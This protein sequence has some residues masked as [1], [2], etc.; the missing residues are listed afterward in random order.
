M[1]KLILLA[2]TLLLI[3]GISA[4]FIYSGLIEKVD[5]KTYRKAFRESYK[6]FT[7]EIPT[8]ASFADEKAPLDHLLVREKLDRE[9]L[10][11]T[12]WHTSTILLIKRANRW[13]PVIEPILK[14]NNIPDDFKYLA[15]IESGLTNVV[16]PKGA[17]GFW[18]FMEDTA[19]EY[20]LEVNDNVDERYNVEKSTEA[21]CRYLQDVFEEYKS[22]T[23]VAAAYNA[24]NRRIAES[25][26]KQKTNNYYDLHLNEETARYVFRILS[27]KTI[28]E[29]PTR[30]GFYLRES[31]LY[32]V[33]PSEIIEV[34]YSL[35]D[36]GSFASEH[37]INYQILKEFNPWL[38]SGQLPAK[39]GKTYRIK[40]PEKEYLFVDRHQKDIDNPGRIFNDTIDQ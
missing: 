18:Q 4:V 16:S 3:F 39:A 22:W 7:P 30:Y 20:G 24:G 5:D 25:L 38:R 14:K 15:L 2:V 37:Q 32:P 6:I 9:F 17:T 21:A 26:E 34:D 13:F 35:P 10:V 11:N 31:D 23:L 8:H 1:K 36:L 27:I 28:Y 40:I 33:I 19:K 29:N 12:Y